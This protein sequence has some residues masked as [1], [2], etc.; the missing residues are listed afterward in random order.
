MTQPVDSA[1][2]TKLKLCA[3]WTSIL[4]CLIFSQYFAL[5]TPGTFETLRALRADPASRDSLMTSSL[6]ITSPIL[7]IFLSVVL[8]ARFNRILNIVVGLIF[9]LIWALGALMVSNLASAASVTLPLTAPKVLQI[10]SAAFGV[11]VIWYAW[12][13]PRAPVAI[14]Q[15]DFGTQ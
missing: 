1:I 10:V 9:V 13:W 15:G 3:L 4:L 12:K 8:P 5:F 14:Q 2:D 6:A 11:L 7:M